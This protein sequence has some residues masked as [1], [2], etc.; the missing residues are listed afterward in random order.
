MSARRA[1]LAAP[2]RQSW[3]LGAI[4]CIHSHEGSWTNPNYGGLGEML[5]FQQ[6]YGADMLRKYGTT[7]Q[8]WSPTDQ[9]IVAWR[10]YVGN[11]HSFSPWPNTARMCGVL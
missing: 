11:G 9:I 6:A 4:L 10:G 7:A 3:F 2:W 8:A 5:A 1:Y